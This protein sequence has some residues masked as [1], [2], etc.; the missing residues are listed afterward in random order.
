MIDADVLRERLE[1]LLQDEET[2]GRIVRWIQL[3]V[4]EIG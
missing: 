3:T 4:E 1:A 2:R